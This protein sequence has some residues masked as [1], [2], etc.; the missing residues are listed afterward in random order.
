MKRLVLSMV[1]LFCFC[2][3]ALGKDFPAAVKKPIKESIEV[4]Q[5]TQ[6][7]EDRWSG[8]KSKLEAKFE[9]LEKEQE[10][11]TLIQDELRKK[12]AA[13]TAAIASLE[14]KIREIARISGELIPYLDEVFGRLVDLVDSGLPFLKDERRQRLNNLRKTLDDTQIQTSEKFRKVMEALLIE[15]EYGNTV[16]VYQER[17]Q[18]QGQDILVNIFRLGRISLFSQ[19]LDQTR[20]GYFDLARSAWKTLPAEYNREINTAIEIGAKRRSVDLINLPVGRVVLK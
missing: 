17:I 12:V 8:E 15:A 1:C 7:A 18:L 10:Q 14:T 13:R 5:K 20:T 4:R 19:S 2:C 9:A 3:P 6:K 16:E 11:L